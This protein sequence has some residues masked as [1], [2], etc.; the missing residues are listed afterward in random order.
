MSKSIDNLKAAQQRAMAIRPKVGGFPVPAETLRQA[1]I[2][3][4][5]GYPPAAESVNAQVR[6][7]STMW[8][9]KL[10]CGANKVV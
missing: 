6:Q 3:K 5:Y 1:G 10:S 4:N 9:V 2:R 8:N 7:V